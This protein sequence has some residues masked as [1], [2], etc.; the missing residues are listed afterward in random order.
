MM[1][2]LQLRVNQVY[3]CAPDTR[4][5][6][7]TGLNRILYLSPANVRESAQI[8]TLFGLE[9]HG[10]PP[11]SVPLQ[12]FST[13][14][15][16]GQLIQVDYQVPL[17]LLVKPEDLKK[18]HKQIADKRWA[19]IGP[20]VSK[21]EESGVLLPIYRGQLIDRAAETSKSS[22]AFIRKLI[23]RYWRYGQ[24]EGA[25][26]PDHANC[27]GRNKIRVPGSVKRGRPKN[28]VTSGHAPHLE[29][30]NIT[31][32]D[33]EKIKFS[34]DAFHI[35]G[36]L[37]LADTYQ[38]L[39]DS[40]YSI[41]VEHNDEIIHKPI[42]AH[43]CP[44]INQFRHWASAYLKQHN[45]Q[46]A[47][48]GDM[49]YQQKKR[50]R[51]GR[52]TEKVDAP[53]DSFEVDATLA[54]VW[55]ISRFNRRR[56]AGKVVVYF[57]VDRATSMITGMHTAFEG[58]SW[59][60]ARL[61]L[62]W[63]FSSKVDYCKHY[64]IDITEDEWPCRELPVEIVSDSG[65]WLSKSAQR[66]LQS[67]LNIN[68]RINAHGRPDRKPIVE[69]RF[70]FVQGNV[71]WV[72]GGYRGRLAEWR[73]DGGR[74][75][76]F[77]AVLDIE[78]FTRMLIVEVLHH[79]NHTPVPHLLSLEMRKDGV[80]PY[81]RDIYLWGL[82]NLLGEPARIADKRRLYLS[83][84][85]SEEASIDDRGLYFKRRYYLPTESDQ[86]VL[87]AKARS[88][89][90]KMTVH[91]DPNMPQRVWV[92]DKDMSTFEA[93]HLALYE[94]D[95][96]GAGRVEEIE[97][98]MQIEAFEAE[99]RMTHERQEGAVK[100]QRSK[101]WENHA[102][103]LQ[104]ETPPLPSKAARTKGIKQVR[105]LE[106]TVEHNRNREDL[107]ANQSAEKQPNNTESK[108]VRINEARHARRQRQAL[109]LGVNSREDE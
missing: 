26:L 98:A 102:K 37:T 105:G 67:V 9:G 65:E 60:A 30:I 91:Y 3:K 24:F 6:G 20:I 69:S 53:T 83:L 14:V 19:L 28:I 56:L 39:L 73:E 8:V 5:L 42:A 13:A 31:E 45:T 61:A 64:G 29:G 76:R 75:P 52:V 50:A 78:T 16:Q 94:I 7:L 89:R 58:P 34:I 96:W 38:H 11:V 44:S 86:T 43:L 41:A 2:A 72:A 47:I 25:M 63:A 90:I 79:N 46:V 55:L 40:C 71:V 82:Q 36:R 87:L 100:R 57:V 80:R 92:V 93:W 62:F 107:V 49:L 101:R 88:K 95:R 109:R 48:L 84:L 104:K 97:D 18:S 51:P 99:E 68:S 32:Q 103:E 21:P 22:R 66:S 1:N 59:N 35:Q 81:R 106:K 74:D 108:I 10:C 77:D 17:H 15:L 70:H 54:N 27:G 23:Y 85:P 12:A 4:P 33:Y